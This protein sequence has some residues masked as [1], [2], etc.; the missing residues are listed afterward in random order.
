MRLALTRDISPAIVRCEL[1]HLAR[2]PIDLGTARRQH[3]A[4]EQRLK[5]AGCSVVRLAAD[6]EMPDSVFIEDVAIVFDELAVI[7]RPGASSRRRETDAVARTLADYRSIVHVDAPGTIDGGDVLIV[8]KRAFVGESLRTNA[9]AISQLARHIAPH[10]YT[11]HIVPV[12]GCLHLKSA[13]TAVADDT[14]LINPEW[15]PAERF[16]PLTLLAVH[17]AESYGANAL[18]VGAELIYPTGFPRTCARLEARGLRVA[19]V[20][21]SEIAKAEGAVTCCSVIVTTVD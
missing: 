20:D 8:G 10:G 11:V 5:E 21:V 7:T 13:V 6:D 18:R 12:R 17:P 1:T 15:V 2:E 14:L 16:R 4:Y 3:D 9:S 19:E